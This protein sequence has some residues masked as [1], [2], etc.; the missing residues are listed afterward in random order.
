MGTPEEDFE[1]DGVV[2]L[3]GVFDPPWIEVLARGVE[4]NLADPSPLA[5][6]AWILSHRSWALTPRSPMHS[7]AESCSPDANRQ[8]PPHLPG[9]RFLISTHAHQQIRHADPPQLRQR[10]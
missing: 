9:T 1:R 10:T 4:R 7:T 3:R 2:C 6:M 5:K 8:H